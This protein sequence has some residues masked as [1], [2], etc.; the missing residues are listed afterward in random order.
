MTRS[1]RTPPPPFPGKGTGKVVDDDKKENR[2]QEPDENGPLDFY[3]V[4]T[5]KKPAAFLLIYPKAGFD[6]EV[7]IGHVL[8][9]PVTAVPVLR[10]NVV[11]ADP[12][13]SRASRFR[14][15]S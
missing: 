13:T 8:L 14:A 1:C 12:R 7:V 10:Q 3:G 9:Y 4:F 11:R 5:A 15:Y 2:K 6:L